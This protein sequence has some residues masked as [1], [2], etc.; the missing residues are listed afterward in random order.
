MDIGEASRL[1]VPTSWSILSFGQANLELIFED[2]QEE[3][4]DQMISE[5][6][7]YEHNQGIKEDP[8]DF[9]ERSLLPIPKSII[10]QEQLRK[11]D[12]DLLRERQERVQQRKQRRVRD[13]LAS[14]NRLSADLFAA[15]SVAERQI[16]ILHDLHSVFLTSYRTKTKD[17]EKGYPLRQNPFYKNIAPVSI[18]SENSEQIWPNALDTFD[19]GV[20]ERKCFIRKIKELVE[21]M[22][23]RRKIV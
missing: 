15:I 7:I 1:L 3:D 2:D 17:Y 19:E 21:N 8:D 13:L 16:S 22:D 5:A 20:R 18:F 6:K 11:W 4:I 9:P 10:T 23:I 14:L 12:E